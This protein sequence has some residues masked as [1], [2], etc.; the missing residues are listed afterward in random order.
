[1]SFQAVWGFDPDEVLRSQERS[2]HKP[3]VD[4]SAYDSVNGAVPS[5]PLDVCAQMYE[6]RRMFGIWISRIPS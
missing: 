3:N 4:E 1:M 5:M 6:L 2:R